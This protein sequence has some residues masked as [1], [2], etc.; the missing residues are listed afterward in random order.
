M[1]FINKVK[2]GSAMFIKKF[3]YKIKTHFARIGG[4]P[5]LY[6]PEY[7][8]YGDS[9]EYIFNEKLYSVL[10]D[11][12]IKNNVIIN[13][14]YGN[15]EIDCLIL[16][17][18]KIFA[19]EIKRWRGTLIEKK[20][21][22]FQIKIDKWTDESHIKILNSPFKQLKRAIYLLRKQI[23]Y[24][25]WVNGIVFFEEASDIIVESDNTE[26]VWFNDIKKLS[27]YIK[28]CGKPVFKSNEAKNF[29]DD[30][31]SADFLYNSYY[32]N[33]HCKIED[34]S[35]N[36]MINNKCLSRKNISR[37]NIK[38]CFSYDKLEIITTDGKNYYINLDNAK[39]N[40]LHDGGKASYSLCKIKY[41]LL[42]K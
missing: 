11:C 36:F 30:C 42:G 10:P 23:K 6:V 40:V 14:E 27:D 38:H 25:A 1:K 35:L 7:K 18:N 20:D 12:K 28:N 5:L 8:R 16:Y 24:D 17:K 3:F 29:F 13:N 32:Y 26:K 37:I 31:S 39:I 21:C 41:I 9:G 15:A 4:N 19:I 33:L 22:F 2:N 34:E